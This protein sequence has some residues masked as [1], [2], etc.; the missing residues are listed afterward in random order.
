MGNSLKGSQP[1]E[2]DFM[3]YTGLTDLKRKELGEFSSTIASLELDDPN[4]TLNFTARLQREQYGWSRNYAK[5]VAEE[6]K[7][8][9]ILAALSEHPVTPSDQVDQAWHLHIVYTRSYHEWCDALFGT[10]LHHGPTKGGD[11][12]K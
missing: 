3:D 1:E 5:R 11:V 9:L 10:Y 6:Y 8:F 12:R 4:S 2:E 7:R